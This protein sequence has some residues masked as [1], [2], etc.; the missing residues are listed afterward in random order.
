MPKPLLIGA[1]RRTSR[2]FVFK[3]QESYSQERSEGE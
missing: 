3:T 2:K 1:K